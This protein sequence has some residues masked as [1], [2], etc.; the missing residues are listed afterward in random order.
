MTT[1]WDSFYL[2]NSVFS[3]VFISDMYFKS[4]SIHFE[5][6]YLEHKTFFPICQLT[7]TLFLVLSINF[8]IFLLLKI[9][10]RQLF[11]LFLLDIPFSQIF[12]HLINCGYQNIFVFRRQFAQFIP[13]QLQ[14][15]IIM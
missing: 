10:D 2:I 11:G 4:S 14:G 5:L 1:S 15:Q 12:Y 7:L 6:S 8:E 3:I 9:R 13:E